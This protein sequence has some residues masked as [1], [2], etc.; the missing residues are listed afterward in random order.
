VST[1]AEEQVTFPRMEPIRVA[2][3]GYGLAGR[4]FHAPHIAATPGL[5]L[6]AIVTS[7]P[8]RQAEARQKYP[9]AR[10]ID[11]PDDLWARA[12]DFDLVVIGAPNGTHVPLA[13]A[14]LGAGLNVVVDKPFAPNAAEGRRVLE[15]ARAAGRQVI[16]FHNRRWDGDLLTLQKLIAEGALGRVYRFDSRFERWRGTPKARW[17]APEAEARAN[18]E[19]LLLDIGPHLVDQA[20]VLFGPVARVYAE[21]GRNYEGV[22]TE[23]DFALLLTHASGVRSH[24]FS[25]AMAAIPG[26]RFT[27]YGT[28]GGYQ[29]FGLD[30]QEPALAAGGGPP[31]SPG[32]GEEP[33]EAWGTFGGGAAGAPRKIRTEPG[34]YLAFYAGVAAALRDGAPPPV[35]AEDA[36]AGLAILDAALVSARQ[37][38]AVA[39]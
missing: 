6:D 10:L 9:G 31:G 16:P 35:S 21:L 5:R 4:V 39:P 32:W 22:T 7:D 3:I 26:P 37:G 29:K 24:L 25:S 15:A 12:S 28:R 2:L 36:V 14:A 13:V 1:L 18:G 27:V 23:D 20:L 34:H 11:R 33:E 8:Q 38:C 30:V 17:Q 19:G